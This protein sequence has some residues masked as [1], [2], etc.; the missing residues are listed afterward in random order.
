[1]NLFNLNNLYLSSY[2]SSGLVFGRDKS[3][4]QTP[5]PL[6]KLFNLNNLYSSSYSSSG[7][8]F[9]INKRLLKLLPFSLPIPGTFPLN[10]I[11]I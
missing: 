5:S 9:G 2:S 7:L 8:V 1:M 10:C 11:D 6:M 3:P 4:Y